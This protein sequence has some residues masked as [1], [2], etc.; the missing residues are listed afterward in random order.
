[1]KR[2]FSRALNKMYGCFQRPPCPS[3]GRRGGERGGAGGGGSKDTQE[4]FAIQHLNG[5]RFLLPPPH[6]FLA[7][8]VRGAQRVGTNSSPH[9]GGSRE[10]QG[11]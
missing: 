1:M 5:G 3:S 4:Q 11:K 9:N 10:R 2:L 7:R 8:L 6:P